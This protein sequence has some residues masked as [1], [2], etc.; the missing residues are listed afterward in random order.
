MKIKTDGKDK[1][2][3]ELT[4]F[5][6]RT[7]HIFDDIKKSEDSQEFFDILEEKNLQIQT[8]EFLQ[9]SPITLIIFFMLNV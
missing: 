3:W 9:L 8:P 7:S 4:L 5:V 6:S 2:E 1:K